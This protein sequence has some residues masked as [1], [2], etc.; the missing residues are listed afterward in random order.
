MESFS[1]TVRIK[2]DFL[3]YIE[4]LQYNA[5][6]HEVF[7]SWLLRYS[8]KWSTLWTDP[9]VL[10]IKVD[11]TLGGQQKFICGLQ[12]YTQFKVT[13]FVSVKHMVQGR[14]VISSE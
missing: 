6:G 13:S 5:W 3:D 7:Y 2:S 12:L 11:F 8:T 14:D 10:F 4:T 1:D 9:Q